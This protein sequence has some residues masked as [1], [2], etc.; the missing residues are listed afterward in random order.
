MGNVFEIKLDLENK[1]R[2]LRDFFLIE[3]A[4]LPAEVNMCGVHI[5]IIIINN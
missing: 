2:N 3:K 1:K 5:F 4:V